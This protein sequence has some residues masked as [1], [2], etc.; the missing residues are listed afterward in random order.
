M[1]D[2]VEVTDA[3]I[4]PESPVT[5]SLLSRLRDNAIAMITGAPGAPRVKP[6]LLHIRHEL[7]SGTDGGAAAATTW[8]TRTLNT[9]VT[10]EIAGASLA[11]N[12]ITLPAGVYDF[13]VIAFFYATDTNRLALYN[14]TDAAFLFY[15]MNAY[16]QGAVNVAN[17]TTLR[18]RLTHA[19][20]KDIYL[21]HYTNGATGPT[22]FGLKM[23]LA[24][25]N[26][27]YVDVKITQVG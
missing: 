14:E 8:N 1:T 25:I 6:V 12:K 22:G 20:A 9:V 21:K 15:D 13:D 5:T 17:A 23:S 10:N 18:C 27:V 19:A 26:E 16:G 3:E 2:Y 7:A 4:D 24:G 11:S